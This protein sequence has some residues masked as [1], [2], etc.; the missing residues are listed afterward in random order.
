MK[1]EMEN[2][3]R[4]AHRQNKGFDK[5]WDKQIKNSKLI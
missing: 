5:T 1:I 3:K 2:F 4:G